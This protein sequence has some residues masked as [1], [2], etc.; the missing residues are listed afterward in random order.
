MVAPRLI[1]A[2]MAIEPAA[3]RRFPEEGSTKSGFENLEC[4][5]PSESRS[6]DARLVQLLAPHINIG[7]PD[8]KKRL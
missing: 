1:P 4:L 3:K 7:V 8:V 6:N 2:P 5:S